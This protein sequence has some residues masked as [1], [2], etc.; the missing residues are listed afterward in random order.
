MKKIILFDAFGTL[1]SLNIPL[2][3]L[4]KLTHGKSE[5]LLEKWRN[6][7]LAQTWLLQSMNRYEDFGKISARALDQVM[8]ELEITNQSISDLLL[9]IY[10]N[11]N[12]FDDVVKGLEQLKLLDIQ[13]FILSNG[14]PAMLSTGI[15]KSKL[16]K[17]LDGFISVDEI[18]AYK[19]APSVYQYALTKLGCLKQEVLFVSSNQ[20]DVAGAFFAG[21][22]TVWLNRQ[23][24]DFEDFGHIPNAIIES[25]LELRQLVS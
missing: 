11:P 10:Q 19:P 1:F 12:M 9:P 17:L 7:Q 18:K 6:K 13:L 15:E 25:M 3:N 4:D 21:I 8:K 24:V 22:D 5:L 23:K 14:T 2:E 16:N 20:W